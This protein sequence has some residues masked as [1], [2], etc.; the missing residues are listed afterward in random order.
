MSESTHNGFATFMNYMLVPKGFDLDT[1]S[2]LGSLFIVSCLVG[3]A[4]MGVLVDRYKYYK[5][6]MI[7][8]LM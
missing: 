4:V 3:S 7:G 1:V 8:N 6:M 2:L 5:P